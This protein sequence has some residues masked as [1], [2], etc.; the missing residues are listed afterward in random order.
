MQKL[1]A[2]LIGALLLGAASAVEF[3]GEGDV[4]LI[5]EGEVV[6]AGEFENGNLELELLAGFTG[7]ATLTVVDEA[8]NEVSVEVMVDSDSSI[9]FTE[10]LEDLRDVVA[11]EGG[12]LK[13]ELE[14]RIEAEGNM[15]FG[16]AVP[17]HVELPEVAREGMEQ[18]AENAA[19]AR[20]RAEEARSNDAEAE[21]EAE[22]SAEARGEV[23]G[24]AGADEDEAEAEA[25][26]SVDAEVGV[27]VGGSNR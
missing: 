11:A 23:S 26:A 15:A 21:A 27:G 24:R 3:T 2:I 17:D 14:E 25:G 1:I 4:V 9:V 7:F 20:E 18:A 22:G 19:E 12:E 16:A 13:V 5:A 6:G 8:G 10:T